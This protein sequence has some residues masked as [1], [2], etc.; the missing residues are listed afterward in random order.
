MFFACD[1]DRQGRR[2]DP[3]QEPSLAEEWKIIKARLVSPILEAIELREK[4][5]QAFLAKRFK[6]AMSYF[7]RARRISISPAEDRAW[8]TFNLGFAS[9]ELKRYAAA[10][11]YFEV[12]RTFPGISDKLRDKADKSFSTAKAEYSK[13]V[14]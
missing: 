2:I 11:G 14:P 5:R 4:G 9:R 7:D 3:G 6:L 10:I 1:P 12:V 8:A 13:A